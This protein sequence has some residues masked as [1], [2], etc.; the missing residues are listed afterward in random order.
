VWTV[1]GREHERTG[2]TYRFRVTRGEHRVAALVLRDGATLARVNDVL[3]SV[4]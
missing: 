4:K 1:D 3:F 2:S